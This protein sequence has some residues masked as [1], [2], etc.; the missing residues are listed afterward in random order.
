MKLLNLN[1]KLFFIIILYI[2][3][4]PILSEESIDIWEKENLKP[5]IVEPKKKIPEQPVSKIKISSNISKKV[6]ISSNS[7]NVGN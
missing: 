4:T 5:N 3:F 2:F 6:N 7:L 1:K